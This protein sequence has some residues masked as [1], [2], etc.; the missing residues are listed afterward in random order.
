MAQHSFHRQVRT[1]YSEVYEVRRAPERIGRVDIHYAAEDV[2][3]TLILENEMDEDAL[4]ALIEEIDEELVLSSEMPRQDF[5]VSVY[6]GQDV[7]L[8]NDDFLRERVAQEA[9]GNGSVR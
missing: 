4:L 6:H 8:Y 3:G 5:L 1:P 2:Y 9:R 7:G